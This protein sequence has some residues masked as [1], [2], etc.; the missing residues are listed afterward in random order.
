MANKLQFVISAVDR[1]TSVVQKVK[2]QFASAVAPINDVG[3]AFGNL[4][5]ETG[6]DRL[7]KGLWSATRAAGSLAGKV[8][9]IATPLGLLGGLGSLAGLASIVTGWGRAGQELQRTS[10]LLGINTGQLQEYRGVAKL[11]GLSTDSMD[12]SLESLGDTMEGA[13]NGR[14][15]QALALMSAWRIGLHKTADGAVDTSRALMDVSRAIQSNLRAGGTVQSARQI[16]QA[17]GVDSLLPL[18]MRGPGY[19]SDMVEQYRRLNA[20]MSPEQIAQ[21]QQY[22]ENVS[23]LE[24]AVDGLK[25]SIGNALIPVLEPAIKD[26]TEWLAIPENKKALI[27]GVSE[28]VHF[29]AN[30]IKSFD[31]QEAKREAGEFFSVLEKTYEL[32]TRVEHGGTRIQNGAEMFGNFLRGYGRQTNAQVAAGPEGSANT[33]HAIDFFKSRGWSEAQ[34]VGLAA[35]FVRESGSDETAIGD[36]GKAQGIAQWHADRQANFAKWSGNGIE[37]STLDQQLGFVDQELRRGTERGA[38]DALAG[39]QTPEQAAAIVSRLYERPANAD[40]E[41]SLRAASAT[42]IAG[43]YGGYDT[44]PTLPGDGAAAGTAGA[45]GHVQVDINLNGAPRGTSTAVRSRG[46]VSPNVKTG[47][48]MDLGAGA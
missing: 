47:Q 16:A 36:N 46:N 24:I 39:A 3:K 14:A 41:A 2:G 33:Q 31:W 4:G 10:T 29:L 8:A 27:D 32:L 42:R 21:G 9:M 43:L 44:T 13:V 20:E 26:M 23:K 7:T 40:A 18:L 37:N 28:A 17:F 5:R 12:A 6:I 11:A 1:A 34:A 30:A 15:P 45:S 25:N 48:A 19:I 22:A 38:G 35:N